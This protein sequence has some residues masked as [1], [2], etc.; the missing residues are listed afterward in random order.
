[1][2]IIK[3]YQPQTIRTFIDTVM[4]KRIY[5]DRTIQRRKVWKKSDKIGYRKSL[6]EVTDSSNIILADI[7]SSMDNSFMNNDTKDYQ[8]FSNLYNQG[9]RY[10][11]I[12]GGNRTDFLI[13]EY[14]KIDRSIPLSD[15]MNDFLNI[16]ICVQTIYGGSKS[17]L[18]KTFI[19]TNSNTSTNSQEK[20]NATE[21]VVSEFIRK[22]GDEYYD[23][24]MM[25]DGLN[26]SRMKELEL[27]TQFLSY[28]QNRDKQMSSKNLDL[29]FE[30]PAIVNEKNFMDIMNIW[31]KSISLINNT[32]SEITRGSSF[33]LFVF[34]LNMQRD[35][36]YVLNKKTIS[37][38]V[39]KYLELENN[40][41]AETLNN[42]LK[43]NWTYLNRSMTKN[44]SYKFE[45]VYNDFL[46]FVNE[47]FCKLDSKR[48]FSK[49]EKLMKCVETNGVVRRL[50]GS[51]EKITPLQALN[52]KN[53]HGH[54]KNIPF[55]KGGN[56][57]YDN[58]ELL[59][60]SDNIK[61]SNKY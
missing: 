15:E 17:H 43:T 41:I 28:H 48:T 55:S 24:L 10:I 23:E 26:Y 31:A 7:K 21:G 11:S 3:T 45:C 29:L 38:F 52:G 46:P 53:I 6:L 60:A 51:I 25:I 9:Y 39:N 30:S 42:P 49:N 14:N 5:N 35:Y 34:L 47:Y 33:N 19:N 8:Y 61:L 36:N 22:I 50:D 20:R 59:V 13:E 37:E 27:I 40:R 54:H 56:S 18:H 58:L 1:M 4:S 16:Q 44:I 12:D 32:K 57:D 2:T